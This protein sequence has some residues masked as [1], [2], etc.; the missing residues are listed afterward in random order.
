[1]CP[2]GWRR[3]ISRTFQGMSV[4][5]KV[6]S[7]PTATHCLWTSSTS[8][9]HTDIQEPLSACSSRLV[10]RLWCSHPAHGL[11]ALPDK[12]RSRIRPTLPH[13][14]LEAFPSPNTYAPA[15]LLEPYEAGGDVGYVQYGSEAFRF[16]DRKNNTGG[17]AHSVRRP[18]KNQNQ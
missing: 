9:T 13:R 15:P 6:T 7:S 14:M 4:G 12:E 11:P 5:G 2:S 17:V 1:M 18:V 10:G 3:C 16:H 8:S